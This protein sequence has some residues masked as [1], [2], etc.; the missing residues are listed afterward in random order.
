[1]VGHGEL[2]AVVVD[3]AAFLFLRAL[4]LAAVA[5]LVVRV[6]PLDDHHH[7]EVGFRLVIGVWEAAG[8]GVGVG[9]GAGAGG[10]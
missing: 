7:H 10:G 8:I 4:R 3:G 1:M 2:K 6:V 9:V 5:E